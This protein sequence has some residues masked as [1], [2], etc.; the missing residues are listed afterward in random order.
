MV[1]LH[2]YAKRSKLILKNGK[3]KVDIESVRLYTIS[4][5][6]QQGG[7]SKNKITRVRATEFPK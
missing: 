1:L 6:R 2:T 5:V 3:K 4:I 7:Q